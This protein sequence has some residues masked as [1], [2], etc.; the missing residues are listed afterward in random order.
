[1]MTDRWLAGIGNA[2]QWL[3]WAV[4]YFFGF[5]LIG[6]A[7]LG[8]VVPGQFSEIGKPRSNWRALVFIKDGK[9]YLVGEAVAFMGWLF[10]CGLCSLFVALFAP[11]LP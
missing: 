10:L 4:G 3:F 5:S 11:A 8:L 7:T 1:M 9:F 6:A 2:T